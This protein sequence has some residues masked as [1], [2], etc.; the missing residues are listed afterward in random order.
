MSED[1]K[2]FVDALATGDNAEAGEAFKTALRDKVGAQLDDRRKELAS[3]LFIGEAEAHSEPKPHVADPSA[4]TE[5]MLNTD[6]QP[7]QFANAQGELETPAA[8]EG[9]VVEPATP[10]VAEPAPEV[11]AEPAPEA[12]ADVESK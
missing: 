5:T 10:E 6:G 8:P 1:V 9:E 12:P 7:I 11:A 2:N 3:N 4:E